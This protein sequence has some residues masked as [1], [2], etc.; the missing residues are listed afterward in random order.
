MIPE[1]GS[2]D[3]VFNFDKSLSLSDKIITTDKET[4]LLN[5]RKVFTN[6]SYYGVNYTT[7]DNK[8][9][10]LHHFK[11]KDRGLSEKE[12]EDKDTFLKWFKREYRKEATT[13]SKEVTVTKKDFNL[14]YEVYFCRHRPQN[15]TQIDYYA[16][17]T[18]VYD[19]NNVFRGLYG[20]YNKVMYD[21]IFE[22]YNGV[23]FI[24]SLPSKQQVIDFVEDKKKS[25][26]NVMHT[27]STE[28]STIIVEHITQFNST[29]SDIKRRQNIFKKCS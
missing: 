1:S 10:I 19:S 14:P 28:Y 13:E 4:Y 24:D 21:E 3:Y 25:L 17:T 6:E 15:N 9:N 29:K 20:T 27:E 18:V 2:G 7:L 11:C 12:V 22:D 26:S 23:A 16:Y 5:V 8:K